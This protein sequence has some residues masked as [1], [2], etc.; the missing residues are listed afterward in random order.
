[1][2]SSRSWYTLTL[3]PDGRVLAAGGET[4]ACSGRI[5]YFG[6]AVA[7]AELYDPVSGT[8][9]ATDSMTTAREIHTATLLNDGK[10][11]VAGG[12][13]W[14]GAF[15]QVSASAE[16]YTPPTLIPAPRLF[17]LSDD[18]KGQGAIWHAATG[19][20]AAPGAPAVAGEALSMYTANLAEGGAIPPQI[21]IG[22][23]LAPILYF[24]DATGYPGFFQVNV[25]VPAGIAPGPAVPVRL[26]YL[27]RS[28]NTVTIA[29]W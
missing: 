19:Q 29:V 18:G 23:R 10:V 2:L 25:A 1:M 14:I 20:A 8:F 15:P 17:P 7:S 9:S 12:E 6:G 13:S 5:C 3:L 21:S 26:T 28:S 27:G 11:L 22:G 16:L 4:E 24:G